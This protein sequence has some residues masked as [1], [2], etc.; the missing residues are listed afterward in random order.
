[1]AGTLFTSLVAVKGL[2]IIGASSFLLWNLLNLFQMLELIP[3]CGMTMPD[4]LRNFFKGFDFDFLPNI[5]EWM[6]DE[7][8]RKL[9]RTYTVAENYEY[10]SS[11]WAISIGEELTQ[12]IFAAIAYFLFIALIKCR[13]RVGNYAQKNERDYRFNFFAR[14]WIELYLF[15]VLSCTL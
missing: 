10:E 7:K 3:L 13:N 2:S 6:V 11:I 14:S 8:D 1:M 12:V 9:Y 5:F 15:M 4:T